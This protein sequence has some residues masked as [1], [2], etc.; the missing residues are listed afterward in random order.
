[1]TFQVTQQVPKL[2]QLD[3]LL[4]KWFPVMCWE[5]KLMTGS[6]IIEKAKSVYDEMEIADK[7]TF[8]EGSNKKLPVRYRYCLTFQYI[9]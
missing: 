5:C 3:K 8:F 6:V 7:N 1:M 2:A 4:C 9:G